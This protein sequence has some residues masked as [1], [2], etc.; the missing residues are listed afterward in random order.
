MDAHV[1]QILGL[2]DL[3]YN[4]GGINTI[5]KQTRR[6]TQQEVQEERVVD[7]PAS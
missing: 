2:P 6:S 4:L 1:E 5:I 3:V 7:Q